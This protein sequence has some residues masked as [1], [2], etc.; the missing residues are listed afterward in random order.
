MKIV[1]NKQERKFYFKIILLCVL[2]TLITL[3]ALTAYVL[4][5]VDSQHCKRNSDEFT[6]LGKFFK[7]LITSPF[8][9]FVEKNE[10]YLPINYNYSTLTVKIYLTNTSIEANHLQD[11][12]T[13][14]KDIWQLFGIKFN[15]TE[16]DQRLKFSNVSMIYNCNKEDVL[17]KLNKYYNITNDTS[18]HILITDQTTVD[19][20]CHIE[21]AQQI[22]TVSTKSNNLGW[23]ITHEIG[24]AVGLR[25][26]AYFSGE[27]N[28]M[29]HMGCIKDNLWPTN[30]NKNQTDY[31]L[32]GRRE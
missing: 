18:I 31:I 16:I 22:I 15:V 19:E 29:T 21:V 24:H 32:D 11:N 27:V 13:Y 9:C 3:A 14:I 2:F 6:C 1:L 25:D 28:L 30:L 7:Y 8:G 12:I 4:Y 5:V 23:A 26:K 17:Q 10:S 20:G